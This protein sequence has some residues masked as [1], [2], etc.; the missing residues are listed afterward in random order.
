MLNW[1]NKILNIGV[2][3]S[4]SI[5]LNKRI[6]LINKAA[7]V[8][9]ILIIP[10]AITLYYLFPKNYYW[11]FLS[12]I[13]AIVLLTFYLNY[14]KL[15][16]AAR[17]VPSSAGS[18]AVFYFSILFGLNSN[19]LFIQLAIFVAVIL[20]YSKEEKNYFMVF[21]LLPILLMIV[22]ALPP[23]N[24]AYTLSLSDL[25]LQVIRYT[26]IFN[27][28]IVTI[29]YSY[30]FIRRNNKNFEFLKIKT[31]TTE[32]ENNNLKKQNIELDKFVY[33]TSHDLKSPLASLKGL[34][35]LSQRET[36]INK[37]KEYLF[38]QEKSVS[39]LTNFINDLIDATKN[40]LGTLDYVDIDVEADI[41]AMFESMRYNESIN[42]IQF[43]VEITQDCK[44]V[45]DRNSFYLIMNNL[46]SNAIRYQ[47]TNKSTSIIKIS[48]VVNQAACKLSIYDTGIGI[49]K[50][51]LDKIFNMFYRATSIKDG[52]GLGLYIVKES[53]NKLGG[54]IE[55]NSEKNEF[56]TF[57]IQIPNSIISNKSEASGMLENAVK[58]AV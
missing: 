14:L 57:Y 28:S 17:L 3:E 54:T 30:I 9:F 38:L 45:S 24:Y 33:Y 53:L 55:V 8:A 16:V 36:D 42:H 37:I 49:E 31:I 43:S 18:L 23:F 58:E 27:S 34:I 41:K 47:K 11:F 29:V 44:L 6:V 32:I 51:N 35:S 1:V 10:S 21:S 56:T 39:K 40:K 5:Q 4:Y 52:S 19:V 22:S 13:G 50:E 48:G 7:L 25:E 20:G 46:L 12:L 15:H 2:Q 26:V